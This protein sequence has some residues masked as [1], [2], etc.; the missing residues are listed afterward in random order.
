MPADYRRL[1]DEDTDISEAFASR[2]FD[3]EAKG[4]LDES[5]MGHVQK[6]ESCSVQSGFG[7]SC[8][9]YHNHHHRFTNGM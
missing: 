2:W 4:S 6:G 3:V 9:V 8:A 1:L 7:G 5:Q